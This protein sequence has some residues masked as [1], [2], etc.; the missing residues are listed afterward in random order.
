MIE[1][2]TEDWRAGRLRDEVEDDDDGIIDYCVEVV[3]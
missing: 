3:E 2:W 1:G